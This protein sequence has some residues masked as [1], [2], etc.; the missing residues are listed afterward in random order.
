MKKNYLMMAMAAAMLASCAQTGVIE[1]VDF[2]ETPQAIG[3]NTFADKQVRATENNDQIYDWDLSDHHTSF[4]V[5]AGKELEGGSFG[6]VYPISSKG[7]VTYSSSWTASPIKYWDKAAKEYYFMAAAPQNAKWVVTTTTDNDFETGTLAYNAFV[8][9]GTNLSV[10]NS[11]TAEQNNWAGDADVDL[12]ISENTKVL[13]TAYNKATPDQVTLNFIH[14][15]SRL[16]IIVKKG[17]DVSHDVDVTALT[18]HNLK[19]KGSFDEKLASAV[20]TSPGTND[21]WKGHDVDGTYTLSGLATTDISSTDSKYLIQ[22]LIIPQDIVEENIDVNGTSTMNQAYF[23][24]A[25]T[26]DGEPY[27]GYYNLA[28]A[29]SATEFNEGWQNTLTITIDPKGITFLG[30]VAAWGTNSY[31]LTIN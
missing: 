4:N 18:V 24:I 3:F 14:I 22:S 5:W 6:P 12:M 2:E 10:K 13:R 1:D 16:N 21:R 29:F 27:S 8:L 7:T 30:K 17:A 15:L 28:K 26:I 20:A 11:T 9:T 25:Y 31:G 23:Y 19:N